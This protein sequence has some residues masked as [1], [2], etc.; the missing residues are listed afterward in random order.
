MQLFIQSI[1]KG[2]MVNE[3][4]PQRAAEFHQVNCTIVDR[5]FADN[6]VVSFEWLNTVIAR[7]YEN[8][9]VMDL[10]K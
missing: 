10:E 4:E 1:F 7:M 9:K 2:L 3:C 5:Q 6:T 8:E